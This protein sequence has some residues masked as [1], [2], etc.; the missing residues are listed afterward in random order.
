MLLTVL[1]KKIVRPPDH[2]LPCSTGELLQLAVRLGSF[3][4]RRIRISTSADGELVVLPE[5]ESSPKVSGVGE[6]EESEELGEI[7]LEEK[8]GMGG[9]L[10]F[11]FEK[12]GETNLNGSSG[13]DDSTLDV[14]GSES[15]ES[16]RV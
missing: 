8:D 1:G 6:V 11:D 5:V 9:Q 2:E 16:L 4:L 14:D 12:G 15:L 10:A 3:Q 13:E 7:V